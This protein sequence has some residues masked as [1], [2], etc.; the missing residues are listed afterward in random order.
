MNFSYNLPIKFNIPPISFRSFPVKVN[1]QTPTAAQDGFVSNP[2]YD[3]FGT[4]AEIEAEVKANPRIQEILKENGIPLQVNMEELEKLKQGHLNDTRVVSAKIYSALPTNLKNEV[5]L[6]DLQMAAILHDYG[7]VL[8]PKSILNKSG[9]LTPDER[10]IM[11][12]HSEIGYELLKHKGLNTQTLNLIK[13]HHQNLNN[14]GYPQN[15]NNF[16]YGIDAQIL[17]TADKYT[18]LREK[19]SYKNPLGKYEALELIAQDVNDGKIKQEVYTALVKG[20]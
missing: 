5:S 16:K 9:K 4:K 2:L 7:K 17:T 13:Y 18:A 11:E 12:S 20:I 15:I 10:K 19:R 14:D 3:T 6:P 8:I 1:T